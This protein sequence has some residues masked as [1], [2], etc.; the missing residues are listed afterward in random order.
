[1]DQ[2]KRLAD[3][4]RSAGPKWQ[5]TIYQGIV[6]SVEGD[7][8]TCTFGS[9]DVSDIRLRASLSEVEKKVLV[10][11]AV[12]SAVI[13]GSLSGDLSNLVVLQVDEVESIVINGGKLGGLVNIEA[14]TEKINGLVNSFNSHTHTSASPNSPT[15]TPLM[16]AETLDRKDYE[17]TKITH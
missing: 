15:S 2:Y 14:L 13:V 8:C 17:D 6:K 16:Q 3:N 12:G 11:P 5:I 7:T 4:L 9:M 10:V 1:M